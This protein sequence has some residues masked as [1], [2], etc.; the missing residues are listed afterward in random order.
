M[1]IINEF[2]IFCWIYDTS[3]KNSTA[4]VSPPMFYNRWKKGNQQFYI[5]Q[6]KNDSIVKEN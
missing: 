3:I 6:L 1:G 2:F 5:C 4:H